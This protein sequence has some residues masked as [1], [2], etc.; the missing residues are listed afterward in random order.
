M[1]LGVDRSIFEWRE[2]ARCRHRQGY[3]HSETSSRSHWAPRFIW[4]LCPEFGPPSARGSRFRVQISLK[5]ITN[6]RGIG[7]R[8]N[9]GQA[10][11][12]LAH[13]FRRRT[14][15][16]SKS[17]MFRVITRS[18]WRSAVAAMSPSAAWTARPAFWAAAVTSPQMRQVSRSIERSR[19]AKS[20]SRVSSQAPRARFLRLSLKRAIPFKISPMEITLTNKSSSSK[21][22]IAWRTPGCPEGRR[23]SESTQVSSRT[24]TI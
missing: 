2:Q 3:E 20:R 23:I 17:A 15:V 7:I 6:L 24:L 9:S 19:S 16:G 21:A 5:C 13:G 22:S 8:P 14:P 1:I 18:P 4:I 10:D 11:F 12:Q